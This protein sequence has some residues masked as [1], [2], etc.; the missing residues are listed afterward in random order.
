MLVLTLGACQSM[1]DTNAFRS[2]Y[3]TNVTLTAGDSGG[4][5]CEPEK[6]VDVDPRRSLFETH[7]EALTHL[8]ME[9]ALEAVAVN[10]GLLSQPAVTHDQLIDTYA[11]GPGLGLG[12]HCD[13]ALAF[14]GTPGLNG[15]PHACPR[16]ES[17][18]LGNLDDWFPIA[19]VNRFDLAPADGANCG[20]ARLVLA[21]NAQN[22]MFTIFEAKVPNPDPACGI[23]A[24]APVQQFWASLTDIDDPALRA[25]EL[26]MAYLDGHPDLLAAGVGP[27]L[28]KNN[29]TFGAGQIRTNNF[30]QFPW[31]L[32]EFKAIAVKQETKGNPQQELG[33]SGGSAVG[34]LRMVPVPVAA[35]PF[36]QL[37][38]DTI[39]LPSSGVC[40]PALVDTVQHL[41]TDDPN[42]MAVDVP[43]ACLAAESPDAA[44]QQYH[45]RLA[46]GSSGP[47]SLTQAIQDEIDAL[48]PSSGLTPANIARRAAF[49]G[50]C[51]GCHQQT[52]GAN[53]GGGVIAPSSAG[54]VHT[55]EFQF[56]DCGNGD[57]SCFFISQALKS[58][59]LPHRESVMET[60]LNGGPCCEGDPSTDPSEPADPV[61]PAEPMDEEDVDAEAFMEAEA[62]HEAQGAQSTIAG[63]PIGRSH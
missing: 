8:T 46:A 9:A 22:R 20:E 21:N 3:T 39:A 63:A 40:H 1:D 33:P 15:Y 37:W 5:S 48:D 34:L 60:Y 29:L 27:F 53:L 45:L 55:R 18:Q 59:F 13:D 36:G 61:I 41:M 42:L 26:R 19:A 14:D 4:P 28:N 10:A 38:T 35:N 47:G 43:L 58:S 57:P 16:A 31:T 6:P 30:D 49:A 54:F 2:T 51:I 17:G 24:C 52:N 11:T 32:R 12:A 50:G 25:E 62:E 7:E 44:V 56:E 23:D